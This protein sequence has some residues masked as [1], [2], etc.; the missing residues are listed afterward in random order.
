MK[1]QHSCL[2]ESHLEGNSNSEGCFSMHNFGI[3]KSSLER[4]QVGTRPTGPLSDASL[5]ELMSTF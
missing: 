5:G 3:K 2:M 1:S 4:S